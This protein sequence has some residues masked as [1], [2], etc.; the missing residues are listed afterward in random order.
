MTGGE[1]FSCKNCS[2]TERK[3]KWGSFCSRS[4]G[5][6]FGN[7]KFKKSEEHHNEKGKLNYKKRIDYWKRSDVVERG[8]CYK[9]NWRMKNV[10]RI[11]RS[12]RERH[13]KNNWKISERRKTDVL[14]KLRGLLRTR[15]RTAL[16]GN[17]K[18]GSA[19][20]SLGCSLDE[21]KKHMESKFKPGMNWDNH[22]LYGWHIDHIKP[23]ASFNL[24]DVNQLNEACHFTNLQPLWAKD[25]LVKGKLEY[26][27]STIDNKSSRD[28]VSC[29]QKASVV[30]W[31][32]TSV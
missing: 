22:G 5:A 25:N 3:E 23:L 24:S 26:V 9:R 21:F 17:Y 15:L 1:S 7:R 4:C 14:F 10:E 13:S 27:K 30:S 31:N 28:N 16:S 19:I 8:K 18:S 32:S 29:S 11:R 6:S 12:D 20:K 2:G